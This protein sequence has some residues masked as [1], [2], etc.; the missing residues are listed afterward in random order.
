MVH[1]P[2]GPRTVALV[3][4]YGSG[5]S[6]LFE[7]LLATACTKL[8]RG[9][10]RGGTDLRVA[11]TSFM[12][13]PWALIDCPGSVEFAHATEHA[14]A[15]A[16]LA[17]VVADPSPA[18]AATV[19]PL[20]HTLKKFHLPFIV[21]LNRIDTLAQPVRETVAALQPYAP[22]RLVQREIPILS[23]ES[24]T[25][26]IDVISERAYD[27]KDEQHAASCPAALTAR[28][29]EARAGLVEVL[30]DRDDALLEKLIEDAAISSSEIYQR[31][32]ADQAE[33]QVAGVLFGAADRGW[34]IFRLWK[35]LRH[36]T[37]CAHETAAHRLVAA[38]GGPLAQVFR[39]QHTGQGGKLSWAR[40][41]RGPLKDGAT[42]NGN[43]LGG[44]SKAPAG[45]MTKLPEAQ[46][47]E[48]VALARL[49]AAVTGG[50]LGEGNGAQF[51]IPE[52]PPPLHSIAIATAD[53]KDDVRLS[54]ALQK[55][56]EEMPGLSVTHSES[57]ETVLGG[58]GEM[59]LRAALERLATGF[60]VPVSS[61]APA[62]AYRETIR[63]PV[64]QHGRLKRQTGGHGQ[65]ADVK[66]EIA[67]LPRGSGFK[68]S[69]K[70]V[71]GAVPRNFI[72]ACGEGAEDAAKKG[73]FGHPVVD[74]EVTLVDGGFHSVD[75]S[76]MAFR[77]ATRQAVLEALAKADPVVLEP[78]DHVTMV[79]PQAYT[80]TAQRLLTGR[81]GQILGYAESE[82]MPGWDEVEGLVPQAD[83]GGLIIDL[84]SQTM[85]LGT[86]RHRFDH[87]AEL[88]GKAAQ[89]RAAG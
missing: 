40:V 6:T 22:C 31:L 77:V 89:Q 76:D 9:A 7:A 70:I 65:F 37:P 78:V 86:Y 51:V 19:G 69:E 2:A 26:F 68:F 66:I 38:E 59:F 29:Q 41:W 12:E 39:T 3:G 35:A 36:D 49:D 27:Y 5:K 14:L 75:S 62:V 79:V 1:S 82:S 63:Q 13:E 21:F 44:I 52:P 54:A 17:V 67:P 34:G 20:L 60:G 88:H 72:P 8:A 81:R 28:E 71:G 46:S 4:P 50:I 47:G 56:C 24:V 11:H 32:Q 84:R 48:V 85:G 55:L 16:D 80:A 53:R 73:V 45:E 23:G 30:A 33:A 58:Q 74:I 83:L 61:H 42:L 57:G 43:R 10:E 15:V 25:G 64:H 18:R 87:L